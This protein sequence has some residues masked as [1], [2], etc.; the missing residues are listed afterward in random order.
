VPLTVKPAEVAEL[1]AGAVT[2][3]PVPMT[4]EAIF[5]TVEDIVD[6]SW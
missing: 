3:K 2:S 6:Y 5:F 1:A 4:A